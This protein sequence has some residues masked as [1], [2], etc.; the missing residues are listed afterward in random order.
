M[1]AGCGR[2][3]ARINNH[4]SASNSILSVVQLH[5]V[6]IAQSRAGSTQ[7]KGRGQ[8]KP[9]VVSH[10]GVLMLESDLQRA[11]IMWSRTQ[12]T[13]YPQLLWLHAVPNGGFRDAKEAV[14]LQSQGVKAGIL[15]L[16]LDVS[17]GGYNGF[18]LEL[19]RPGGKC[20]KPS[21][22]QEQYMQFCTEQGY[23]AAIS[24]DFDECKALILD[25][26]EGRLV[27]C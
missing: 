10:H 26:L 6:V 18:K 12:L 21:S 3:S 24:N 17:R 16:A 22:D 15:D 27:R 9:V 11:I 1:T 23:F 2:G 8:W 4:T 25:Y 20:A 14:G 19:K 5:R 7:P 13:K